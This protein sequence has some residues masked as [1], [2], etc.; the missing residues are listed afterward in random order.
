M[1]NRLGNRFQSGGFTL[2]EVLIASAVLAFVVMAL[3]YSISAAQMHVM[4]AMHEDRA[5][6]LTE[7]MIDE[8]LSLPYDDPDGASTVGPEAGETSRSLFDN[9]DD[10]HGLTEALGG[11][12]DFNGSGYSQDLDRFSRS[13]SASYT[14]VN[15]PSLGGDQTGL[16]LIV[17]VTDDRSRTWSLSCFVPEPAP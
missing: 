6:S 4:E 10:Y 3:T 13:V 8:V 1:T 7:A 17:T 9:I 16:T 11:V 14:T 12:A 15:V 2:A 5:I